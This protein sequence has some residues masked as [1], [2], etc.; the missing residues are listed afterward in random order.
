MR[1]YRYVLLILS[2]A[3]PIKRLIHTYS[4]LIAILAHATYHPPLVP[5]NLLPRQTDHAPPPAH[6]HFIT[7][8][9]DLILITSF[10]T[11]R[12]ALR[13]SYAFPLFSVVRYR[14]ISM[15]LRNDC[16]CYGLRKPQNSVT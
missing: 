6:I 1:I 3:A 4:P 8:T 7:T 16:S 14:N 13:S 5:S 15:T 9:P 10:G 11:P 2:P 12:N